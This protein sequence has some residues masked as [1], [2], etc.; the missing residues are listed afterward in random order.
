MKG[1]EEMKIEATAKEIAELVRQLQ[2][3]QR[4]EDLRVTVDLR[5]CLKSIYDRLPAFSSKAAD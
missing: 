1:C 3:R 2:A 4:D 5:K